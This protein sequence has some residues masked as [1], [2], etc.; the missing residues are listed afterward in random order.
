LEQRELV[1]RERAESDRRKVFV[2][3]TDKAKSI[4]D[5]APP[6][7]QD[8]FVERFGRLRDWEQMMLLSSLQRVAEL[9][10]ADEIDAA[11]LL[12]P[13]QPADPPSY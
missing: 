4:I 1:R 10:D 6:L 2:F 11:P 12:A 13:G 8:K 9:M 5:A 3:A 7:L